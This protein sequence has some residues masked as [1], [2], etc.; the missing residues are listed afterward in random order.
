MEIDNTLKKTKSR[1]VGLGVFPWFIDG[2]PKPK[3]KRSRSLDLREQERLVRRRI[4]DERQ[5]LADAQTLEFNRSS[6]FSL[7]SKLQVVS[8]R[9]VLSVV[10]RLTVTTTDMV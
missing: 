6:L 8:S 5:R 9:S 1:K 10:S 4:A 7:F 2:Q 3:P